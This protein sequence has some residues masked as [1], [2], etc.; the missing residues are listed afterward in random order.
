[1]PWWVLR[2][3]ESVMVN[4]GRTG[5]LAAEAGVFSELGLSDLGPRRAVE[6]GRGGLKSAGEAAGRERGR[7]I[8]VSTGA[9]AQHSARLSGRERRGGWQLSWWTWMTHGPW[10]MTLGSYRRGGCATGLADRPKTGP[11]L[12]IAPLLHLFRRARTCTAA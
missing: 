12:P 3:G 9:T 10:P 5:K 7:G 6:S 8:S 1:M 4:P 11:Q 2:C